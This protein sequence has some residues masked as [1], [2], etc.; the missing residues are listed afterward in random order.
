[1]P[2]LIAVFSLLQVAVE[3]RQ[4]PWILW[5]EDLSVADPYY[6][7]PLIFGVSMFAQQ[8]LMPTVTDPMQARIMMIMPVMLTVMF[9]GSQSGL[10]IYWVTSTAFGVGQQFV[11]RKY[12]GPE[13]K[14]GQK[15]KAADDSPPPE[16]PVIDVEPEPAERYDP[17]GDDTRRRRRRRKK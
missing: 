14:K 7:L 11:I 5:I 15:K 13:E 12:W 3:L 1:M 9:I 6:V 8:K 17:E 2:F 16:K 4:A 10:M